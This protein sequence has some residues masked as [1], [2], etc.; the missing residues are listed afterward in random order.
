MGNPS[1][2]N[3]AAMGAETVQNSTPTGTPFRHGTMETPSTRQFFSRE[4][5]VW[6]FGCRFSTVPPPPG[7]GYSAGDI[8][9]ERGGGAKVVLGLRERHRGVP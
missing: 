5:R 7:P 9:G 2:Q 6:A 4:R 1:S 8:A 3:Y